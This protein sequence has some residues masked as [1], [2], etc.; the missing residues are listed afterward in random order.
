[1]I[2][3]I[4]IAILLVLVVMLIVRVGDLVSFAKSTNHTMGE[5]LK[6]NMIIHDRLKLLESK[7][8]IIPTGQKQGAKED[9]DRILSGLKKNNGAE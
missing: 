6:I 8:L 1:M 2:H 3:S 9:Y 7:S 4:A 5:Q